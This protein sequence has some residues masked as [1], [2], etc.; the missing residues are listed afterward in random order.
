MSPGLGTAL[1]LLGGLAGG[2]EWRSI[3]AFSR[4]YR[5]SCSTCHIAPGKLNVQGEAF[6]L[7]GY[8]FPD[9]GRR[10]REDAV[11]LGA[12]PWKDLW[13]QAVWPG[14]IPGGL[15]LSLYIANDTRVA[16]GDDGQVVA[17]LFFPTVVVL[18]AGASLGE[19]IGAFFAAGWIPGAGMQV[20]EA[21]AGLLDPIPGLPPRVLNL[22][23]G[24]Q[25]P[26]LLTFGDFSLDRGLR[27]PFLWQRLR[28]SEWSV[29]DAAG[30]RAQVAESSFNLSGSRPS[31]EINGLGAGRF[32][33][34][35][36]LAQPVSPGDAEF[37]RGADLYLK[38]RY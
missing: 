36:G 9:E 23:L 12:D 27:Q 13:P 22:W 28:L 30:Q 35:V 1:L 14:E 33:Y 26:H 10:L 37:G 34:A 4:A 15:P 3:P 24:S 29:E 7:N 11:P 6:R 2:A 21:K 5:T 25:R 8:R 20:F 31:I 18:H 19:G 17:D 32:Y 16:R 38:L